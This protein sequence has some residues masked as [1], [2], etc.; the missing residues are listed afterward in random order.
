VGQGP[1]NRWLRLPASLTSLSFQP[2]EL[3]KLALVIYLADVLTRCQGR[4]ADFRHGLLPRLVVVLTVVLCI[5]VQ[6]DL[7]TAIAVGLVG[8]TML[9]VGGARLSHLL[10]VALSALPLV[11]MSVY[12]LRYQLD[13]VLAYLHGG[14]YQV[15]QAL[16][17]L[18][19]GGPFGVGLGNSLQKQHFLPEPHTDFVFALVG[20]ELGLAGTLSVIGLFVAF[21][22]QGLRIARTAPTYHA[23]LL[24][25]GITAMISTY[26]LLNIG[27]V[28]GVLPTTG[29]PLPFISYGGSALMVNLAA[30][31][32]LVGITRSPTRSTNRAAPLYLPRGMMRRSL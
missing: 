27:V 20:E 19:S 15:Q 25:T 26:A 10:M 9:W 1:T 29:L 11:A 7:G 4:M 28:T 17:A 30:V 8:L 12:V 24:A 5:A 2:S 18:G 22:I 16:V 14:N 23:R 3:A 31:G 6:P 32:I 13:R 21:A